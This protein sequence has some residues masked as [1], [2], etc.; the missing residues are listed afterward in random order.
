METAQGIVRVAGVEMARALRVVT[1]ERGVDPRGHALLAFGGAG[2]LHATQIADELGIDRVLCPRA[3]GVLAALGL[4]VSPGR[5]DAQRSV[6]LS[7]RQLTAERVT[8]TVAELAAQAR[9]ALSDPAAQIT[10]TYELRYR[11]QSFELA[12]ARDMEP[13]LDDLRQGFEAQHQEL[14]GY[15]DPELELELVTIRASARSTA[16]ALE[17]TLPSDEHPPGRSRRRAILPEGEI[18]LEVLTGTPAPGMELAGPAV[19]ELPET[20]LL[21][22][23]GWDATVHPTGTLILQR[24]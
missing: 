19:I 20:T 10:V 5:R 1:V 7:G 17:L 23:P 8:E 18:E 16:A 2:P 15:V 3:S 12:V 13:T 11:G 14:Y 21:I 4:V 6:L 24:R 9:D 22:P